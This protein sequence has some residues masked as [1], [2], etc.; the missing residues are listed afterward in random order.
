VVV[1]PVFASWAAEES[2]LEG[3]NEFV[4]DNINKIMTRGALIK[5]HQ[6]NMPALF[7][8]LTLGLFV[9]VVIFSKIQVQYVRL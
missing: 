8:E 5:S 9:L 7:N 4:Y 2:G 1:P 6:F 3:S